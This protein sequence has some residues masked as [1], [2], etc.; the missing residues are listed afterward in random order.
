MRG[1]ML[2]RALA[3]KHAS[4]DP[5]LALTNLGHALVESRGRQEAFGPVPVWWS[6]RGG[7]VECL[8]VRSRAATIWRDQG[9]RVTVDG[10]TTAGASPDRLGV[11]AAPESM[12]GAPRERR[13]SP[14]SMIFPTHS[15][16]AISHVRGWDSRSVV[17]Q[18]HVRPRR[19]RAAVAA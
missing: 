2:N 17:C 19:C 16:V 8:S 5:T 15:A 13:G 3:P 6:W 18:H 1:W 12:S 9:L 14:K 4:C 11:S 10:G 7:G